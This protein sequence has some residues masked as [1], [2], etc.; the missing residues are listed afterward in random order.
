MTIDMYSI[1]VLYYSTTKGIKKIMPKA[2]TEIK[3]SNKALARGW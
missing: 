2:E 1:N 3:T